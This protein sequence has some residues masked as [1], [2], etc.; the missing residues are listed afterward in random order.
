MGVKQCRVRPKRSLFNQ[1]VLEAG[2]KVPQ[3]G[4]H[5]LYDRTHTRIQICDNTQEE[6]TVSIWGLT[7]LYL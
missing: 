5:Y 2:N 4:I 1:Q 6:Y 3:D 7:T